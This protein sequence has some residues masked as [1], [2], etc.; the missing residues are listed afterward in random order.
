MFDLLT[1]DTG[2]KEFFFHHI[3]YCIHAN[4]VIC[5]SVIFM[6]TG[7]H[8]STII[9]TLLIVTVSEMCVHVLD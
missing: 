4:L 3:K 5:C 8:C 2:S 1:L 7:V 9:D 6:F